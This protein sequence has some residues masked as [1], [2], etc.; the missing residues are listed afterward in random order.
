M[1][2]WRKLSLLLWSSLRALSFVEHNSN[3]IQSTRKPLLVVNSLHSTQ[4][5]TIETKMLNLK[6]DQLHMH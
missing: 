3:E 6:C 2:V 5:F 4:A 1:D